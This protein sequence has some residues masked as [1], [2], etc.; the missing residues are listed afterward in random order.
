[1]YISNEAGSDFPSLSVEVVP[2]SVVEDF[3]DAHDEQDNL[4]V[5]D[6]LVV[7]V[8]KKLFI[9]FDLT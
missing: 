8:H 2:L 7:C 5:G 6:G 1:V 4:E 9:L 3:D